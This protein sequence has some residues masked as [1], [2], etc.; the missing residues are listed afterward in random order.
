MEKQSNSLKPKIAYGLFDWASSPVPTLHATFV[1]AVYYVSSVSPDTGSA[2]WAWMNSLA[3][4]TIAIISPILGASADRNANRKTWL[5][6]MMAVGIVATSLLW[7]VEPNTSWIWYALI[8]SFVSIVAMESLFTFYNA[9]LPSIV[10]NDKIGSVSGFSWAAGYFGAIFCLVIVLAIFILPE[11]APFGLQKE[12]AEQIRITM[13]FSALWFL[14]FGLPLF[15]WISEPRFKNEQESI[16]STIKQGVHTAKNIPGMVRFLIARMLYADALVVVYAFG[17][18][19]ATN[20]FGFTQDE[21]IGFAIAINLTAG[22]GAAF[23]GR[24]EDRFGGFKTIRFSLVSLI[25]LSLIVLIAPSKAFFWVSALSMGIFIGPLQSAS[26]TVVAR[27]VPPEQ[28]ARI[29]GLYMIS[30]KATSFLGPLLYGILFSIFDT[31]RAG[32][33]IAVVFL[34]IGYVLLGREMNSE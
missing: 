29:F 21:V 27:I 3:A 17:G 15:L 7:W 14:V 32:M 2:E 10:S 4:L 34:V 33:A 23:M 12:Q 8:I 22:I 1:F 28:M 31:D 6:L 16:I 19:Y 24:L 9:L 26:R 30:G 18:I 11:H 20:V 5:G 13:P 25:C